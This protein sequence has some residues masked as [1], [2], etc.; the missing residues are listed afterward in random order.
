MGGRQYYSLLISLSEIPRLFKFD[1]WEQ[2]TPVLRAQR[3]LN[4]ARVADIARYILE[5]EDR[6]LFSSITA[7]YSCPV[8]FI[9]SIDNRK[10]E[11]WKWSWKILSSPSTTAS[12]AARRLLQRSKKILP[13]GKKKFRC[14]SLRPKVR[15][16]AADV[17]GPESVRSEELKII[18]DVLRSSR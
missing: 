4:K 7:S 2:S 10:L 11:R 17:L 14:F 1:D 15:S 18:G 3:V 5:N 13:W 12:I 6:Y 8:T 9:P 16:D